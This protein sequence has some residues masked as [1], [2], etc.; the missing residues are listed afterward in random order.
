M[1]QFSAADSVPSCRKSSGQ[2]DGRTDTHTTRLPYAVAPP[3]GIMTRV[4]HKTPTKWYEI[5]VALDIDTSTLNTM[6]AQTN[7]QVRLCIMVFDQ[8]KREHKIPYT[9]DTIVSA[10]ETVNELE[11]AAEIKQWLAAEQATS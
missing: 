3:L 4:A 2:T 7:D 1:L 5:G 6:K 9:W 10:L 8:W 11:T